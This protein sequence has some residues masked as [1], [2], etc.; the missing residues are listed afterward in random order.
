MTDNHL[1]LYRLAELMLDREQ[2]ILPVDMLFDDSQIGYFVKSIQIDSPYQQLLMEGVLTETVQEHQLSVTFTVEGYFHYLLGDWLYKN[3]KDQR[4]VYLS[5]LL[6]RNRLNGLNHA[7]SQCLIRCANNGEFKA[8]FQLIDT[9]ETEICIIPLVTACSVGKVQEILEELIKNESD[10]DYAIVDEIIYVFKINGKLSLIQEVFGFFVEFFKTINIDDQ[11]FYRQR[12]KLHLLS[13]LEEEVFI[14]L[15]ESIITANSCFESFNANQRLVLLFE[16][17][18]CV[19]ERGLLN[20]A[21][22]FAK[23]FGLYEVDVNFITNNYYNL[24]YPLLEVGLFELAET[25]YWKCE[26][27]NRENA[28]FLNWSGFLYQSWYELK[29]GE[30]YHITRALEL[31][32]RSSE[33]LDAEYG[34]YSIQKYQN[35]ENIGYTYSLLK[36]YEKSILILNQAIDIV[37][38]TYGT[39]IVYP[40]GNLYEM[41]AVTFN[42]VGRYQEA[43]ELTFLSDQSKLL[44]ISSDSP[45]MAWNHFDRSEIY[46]NL[47]N[48]KKALDEMRLAYNIRRQSL[49]KKNGLTIQT[50]EALNQLMKP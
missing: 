12:L 27:L 50:R 43:L 46:Q 4:F 36:N 30:T 40:L 16:L 20:L 24:I 23:Q 14:S 39:K 42:A 21:H 29:S 25:C 47:G 2:H 34:K 8:I 1:L 45:E 26:P 44:Q 37:V 28:I 33:L 48:K 5:E 9:G 22:Q 38:K 3:S 41:L 13:H 32:Q 15:I 17:N 49:G 11:Y 35:L 19:V 31:Y 7:I 6:N 18:T 10:H